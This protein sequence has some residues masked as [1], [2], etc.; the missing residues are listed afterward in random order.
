M[1][2]HTMDLILC[3]GLTLI[4]LVVMYALPNKK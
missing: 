4:G 2:M 1:S 3:F